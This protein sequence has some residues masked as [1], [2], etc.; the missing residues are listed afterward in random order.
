MRESGTSF[1]QN[2][3]KAKFQGIARKKCKIKDMNIRLIT[4][5]IIC[6]GSNLNCQRINTN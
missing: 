1:K 5:S 2:K 4:I 3:K 6:K